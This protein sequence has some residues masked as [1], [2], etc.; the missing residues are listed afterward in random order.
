LE[1]KWS[2]V[3]KNGVRQFRPFEDL[4]DFNVGFAIAAKNDKYGFIDK[5]GKWILPPEFDFVEN[6][7]KGL[8][9][10]EKEGLYGIADNSGEMLLEPE[11][12][13]ALLIYEDLIAISQKASGG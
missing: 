10:V 13:T 3:D 7:A 1:K 8:A 6:F 5:T 12:Y 11:F 2:S 9:V 4:S